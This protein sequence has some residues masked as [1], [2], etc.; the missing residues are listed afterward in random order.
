MKANE[1]IEYKGH[2]ITCKL[3]EQDNKCYQTDLDEQY[4]KT[5]GKA[6]EKIDT[7]LNLAMNDAILGWW[8]ALDYPSK[9]RLTNYLAFMHIEGDFAPAEEYYP[10]QILPYIRGIGHELCTYVNAINSRLFTYSLEE[11]KRISQLKRLGIAQVSWLNRDGDH[12]CEICYIDNG[13][14]E[15]IRDF[16]MKNFRPFDAVVENGDIAWSYDLENLSH[17]QY[18]IRVETIISVH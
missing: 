18:L 6:K 17:E 11:L 4:H 16:L 8:Q 1:T 13:N 14:R 10:E 9:T 15:T 2:T 12:E 5:I 7:K 3:N